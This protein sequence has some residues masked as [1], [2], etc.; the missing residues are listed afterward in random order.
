MQHGDWSAFAAQQSKSFVV[1]TAL[2]NSRWYISTM[3]FTLPN[4]VQP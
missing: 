2:P 4:D 1:R 3:A